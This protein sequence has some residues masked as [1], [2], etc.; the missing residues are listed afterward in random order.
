[1]NSTSSRRRVFL[2]A[3]AGLL[4]VPGLTAAQASEGNS[5]DK[6]TI[7]HATNSDTNPYVVNTPNKNGDVS[8]HADHDGPVWN[9][10]LKAA[11]TTWGDIIPPFDYNDHGEAAHFPG[12]NWDAQ[13]QEWF[14]NGCRAL[15]TAELVKTN[16]ANGDG[17]FTDD[18]T[19][20]AVGADVPFTVV[21][22]NTSEVPAMVASLTDTVA[23]LP[24]SFTATPDPTG[25]TLAA[26]ASV[27]VT[28]AAP[29]YSPADGSSKVNTVTAVLTETDD[30]TNTATA[31]DTSTVRTV[32]PDVAVL[33]E[34]PATAAP[35]D[36]ITWTITVSNTGTVPAADVT[37]TD[38]LPAGTTLVS[39]TGTDWTSSG[40]TTLTLSYGPDLAPGGSS[41][42]TVVATL[43]PAFTGTSIS[44]TAVVTPDD[45]TP[46]DNTSTVTTPVTQPG[47]GGGGGGGVVSPSPTVE[48]SPD[49]FG[50]GGVSL[51]SPTPSGFTGGGGGAL[52]LPLTG[53]P[54][55]A[56]L[57]LA[58]A[59]LSG[60]ASLVLLPRGTHR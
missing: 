48:P 39:A 43:D 49:G 34:G 3:T 25:T 40:T 7:C 58:L 38:A 8:G 6:Q 52:D 12:Q 27:T 56:M 15:I 46:G 44:N 47:G 51:P 32:L 1:V 55:L 50:G 2:A 26:G 16:D 5:N 21:I 33:K 35:G 28:L 18:E 14:D 59:L 10:T 13:G 30:A 60:G 54:L 31:S 19:A 4:A 37:V 45:V 36:T 42:V 9:P 41:V 23:G 57:V 22:T 29:G 17:T 24:V 11:H 53:T 20:N